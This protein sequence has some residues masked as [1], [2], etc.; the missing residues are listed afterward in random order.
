MIF[1]SIRIKE[2]FT[3]RTIDFA[4]GVNLIFSKG[5]SKGKTTLLRFMLYSL[6][7]NIPNT[8]KIK[9]DRCEVVSTILVDNARK[10]ALARYSNDF[11]EAT[12]ADEK[13]TYI[14]PD[15]LHDLHK[16]IFGTDNTDVLNN[17]LG[18][19][20]ADQEK[21]WTLLNRGTAIGSIRFNIE[22]LIRGLSGC[23]CSDLIRKEKQLAKELSKYRQMASV[24]KYREQVVAE[25]GTLVSDSYSVESDAAIAQL[26]MQQKSL[27]SEL[28]RIDKSLSDNKRVRQY[29]AEMKLTI[30]LPDGTIFPVTA[31]SIVGL[32]DTIDF[33]IAKRKIISADLRSVMHQ[34]A[35][36]QKEQSNESEQLTLFQSENMI[37]IFDRQISSVPINAIAI[38]KEIK[39]LEKSLKAVKQEITRQTRSDAGVTKA[40]YDNMVKY[41]TELGVGNSETIAS[42]YLFTSNLKE[43]S[44]AVLHKTVFAFRLAYI[45]EIE[46]HLGI[47]LPIILDSHSGKEV[48]QAN[49]Q[50]MVNILKRD[51]SDN[52]IIIASIFQYDFETVKT[53]E[54]VNRLIED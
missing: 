50:L 31:D 8:R 39:R 37:D 15:Q 45:I 14:L 29:V 26:L 53:I 27:Q 46:K 18:A 12:I 11:I 52:Q 16:I 36:M 6:G 40:L 35:A 25:S 34:L 30:Q 22:E 54:I 24:A 10:M 32:S 23:D 13:K 41:A 17:I 5:N 2:G 4:D 7:Y 21:G 51:F 38:E 33:L 42:S 9:F 49:I 20:Y 19:I 43:L 44:G 48:D 47:K 1:Q 3:E 28:K